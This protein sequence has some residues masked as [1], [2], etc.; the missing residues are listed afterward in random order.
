[1]S[2][3]FRRLLIA[4]AASCGLALACRDGSSTQPVVQ[5]SPAARA[6]VDSIYLQEF[7][8]LER[9]DQLLRTFGDVAPFTDLLPHKVARLRTLRDAYAIYPSAQVPDPYQAPH[10]QERFADV[11][12]ACDVAARFERQIR[13]QYQRVL[14]FP[15]P[16]PLVVRLR[17]NLAASMA[18]DVPR[19]QACR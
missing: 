12:G 10:F 18:V 4:V 5:F 9:Y 1:M 11:P 2:S 3:D 19:T 6:L 8:A 14:G 16:A 13:D 7:R 17:E 15:L